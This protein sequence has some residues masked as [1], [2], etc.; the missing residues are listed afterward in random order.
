MWVWEASGK[1]TI[2]VDINIDTLM[3]QNKEYN[4]MQLTMYITL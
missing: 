1:A 3:L 2:Q 4:T